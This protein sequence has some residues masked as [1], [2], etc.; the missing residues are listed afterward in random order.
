V[1]AA[2]VAAGHDV[3]WAGDWPSDP[4]DEEILGQAA[5]ES[6]VLVTLDKD[7]GELVVHQGRAH[8]GIVRLVSLASREQSGVCAQILFDFGC[9]APRSQIAADMLPRHALPKP[10]IDSHA[11]PPIY[12]MASNCFKTLPA[13]GS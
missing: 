11:A 6:R 2:L 10:K 9:V 8:C 1:R 5:A 7:F 3:I 4:G 12:E 13:I